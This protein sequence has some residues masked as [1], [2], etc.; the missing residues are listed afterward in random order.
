ML[1]E[2]TKREIRAR[3]LDIL[4]DLKNET[5]YEDIITDLDILQQYIE[6]QIEKCESESEKQGEE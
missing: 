4:E 6:G 5:N 2:K 3:V 1:L